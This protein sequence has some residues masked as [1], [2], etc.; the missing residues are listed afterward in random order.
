[1]ALT[2]S[3]VITDNNEIIQWTAKRKAQLVKEM[4]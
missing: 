3:G 2:G 1:M 4:I